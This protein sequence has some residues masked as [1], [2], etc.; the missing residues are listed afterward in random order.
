MFISMDA[1]II[2]NIIFLLL[3]FDSAALSA[4]CYD[5]LWRN[6]A[7]R[8]GDA[9]SGRAAWLRPVRLLL[10][11]TIPVYLYI[12]SV[13]LGGI[14]WPRRRIPAKPRRKSRIPRKK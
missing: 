11:W 5:C 8:E 14:V 13:G 7:G 4:D 6:R 2:E 9:V 12:K 3:L 1:G 10:F